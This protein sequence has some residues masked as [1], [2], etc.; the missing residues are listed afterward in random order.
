M[1][2]RDLWILILFLIALALALG[3]STY[4]SNLKQSGG[5]KWTGERYTTHR[6]IS[7]QEAGYDQERYD[8]CRDSSEENTCDDD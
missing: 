6:V 1:K 2:P 5:F 3:C 8:A 4:R 7:D